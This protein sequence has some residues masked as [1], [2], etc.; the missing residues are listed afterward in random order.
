MFPGGIAEVIDAWAD[1]ADRRMEERLGAQGE[2]PTRL[3]Q[4]VRE[5]VLIRLAILAPH[6]EAMQRAV[7]LLSCPPHTGRLA[8]AYVRTID[9]IWR[10]ALDTSGGVA[11]Y[12]K[13]ASLAAVY[14]ATLLYWLQDRS[15][16][17]RATEAFLDRRLD[18]LARIGKFRRQ[19]SGGARR[20][21][22]H[23]TTSS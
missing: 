17:T 15:E 3:S 9:A 2:L 12:T 20:T 10:A 5:A 22:E 8:R 23:G 19:L 1:L 11:W 13:R 21:P 6:K 14:G 4:R 7:A 18:D 16:G